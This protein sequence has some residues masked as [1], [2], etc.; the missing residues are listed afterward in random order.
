[1]TIEQRLDAIEKTLG[2]TPE[3]EPEPW[4]RW[5]AENGGEYWTWMFGG[6]VQMTERGGQ[7]DDI[8]YDEG[9]Y[10]QSKVQAIA[11]GMRQRSM[12]PTCPMPQVGDV[13]WVVF[14]SLVVVKA[15]FNTGDIALHHLGRVHLTEES[16]RAWVDEFA[17]YLEEV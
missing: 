3:P 8:Y 12:A 11:H 2:I 17:K 9:N 15:L 14:S 16:A 5:R 6:P 13:V 4:K 10:H 1:M 7:Y